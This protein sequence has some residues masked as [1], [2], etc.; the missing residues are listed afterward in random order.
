M[1]QLRSQSGSIT[2]LWEMASLVLVSMTS[3]PHET[4]CS[5]FLLRSTVLYTQTKDC[6][7][8]KKE[9]SEITKATSFQVYNFKHCMLAMPALYRADLIFLS[10]PL[11]TERAFF[12]RL[13]SIVLWKEPHCMA[14][15]YAEASTHRQ[16]LSTNTISDS[17]IFGEDTVLCYIEITCST[18]LLLIKGCRC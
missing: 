7:V 4:R 16:I 6:R 18:A 9:Y 13:S 3:W 10:W 5:C 14:L 8:G 12:E 1:S 15:Y 2:V 17:M 11:G